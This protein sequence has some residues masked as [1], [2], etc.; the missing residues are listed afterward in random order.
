MKKSNFK[1][2]I[3]YAVLILLV[4]LVSSTLFNLSGNQDLSYSQLIE[5][6]VR[7]EVKSFTVDAEGEITV[8]KT[9]GTTIVQTLQ[10]IDFFRE[11]VKP[12]VEKN[13]KTEE[14]GG[15]LE[16]YHYE[17]IKTMPWWVSFLPYLVI[18]AV[19]VGLFIYAMN[20][21]TGGKGSR[22]NSFGK[23]RAKH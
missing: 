16:T 12:Y 13:R 23:A 17:P 21:A 6:F 11:D 1:V 9:D 2:I 15:N 18:L 5:L 22:I 8:N 3:F 4:I 10:D 19:I 7:D 20:Q 14:G